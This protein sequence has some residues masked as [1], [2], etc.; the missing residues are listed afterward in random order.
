MDPRLSRQAIE[1]TRARIAPYL[2]VTPVLNTAASSLGGPEVPL[3]LK[4]EL[5][6][7]AGSFKARGAF[8]SLLLRQ[9]PP[10]DRKSVV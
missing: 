6:Q 4:L 2:R 8:A 9:V 7:H 1:Q 10:A 5:L 3:T